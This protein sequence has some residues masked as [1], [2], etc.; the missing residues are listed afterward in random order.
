MWCFAY[1]LL[2]KGDVGNMRCPVCQIERALKIYCSPAN[3]GGNYLA[4]TT[5]VVAGDRR[6]TSPRCH[7]ILYK[8]ATYPYF[9]FFSFIEN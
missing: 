4:D 7:I 8:S 9:L 6:K 5:S 1:L 3:T 2:M